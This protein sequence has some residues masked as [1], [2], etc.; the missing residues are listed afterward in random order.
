MGHFECFELLDGPDIMPH[1]TL[2]E[3]LGHLH[4]GI[5]RF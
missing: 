1:Q 5:W 2:C 3:F 4:F